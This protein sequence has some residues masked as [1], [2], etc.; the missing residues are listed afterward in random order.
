VDICVWLDEGAGCFE[1]WWRCML[2]NNAVVVETPEA[3]PTSGRP[4]KWPAR[5]AAG[6]YALLIHCYAF[7]VPA[8]RAV[9]FCNFL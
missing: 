8:P 7:K 2:S 5:Q 3:G 6:P 9:P 1:A 4:H